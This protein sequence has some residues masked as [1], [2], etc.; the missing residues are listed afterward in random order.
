MTRDISHRGSPVWAARTGMGM[1]VVIANDVGMGRHAAGDLIAI[2]SDAGEIVVA[3]LIGPI[4]ADLPSQERWKVAGGWII[5][6]SSPTMAEI[7]PSTVIAT[8]QSGR[9]EWGALGLPDGLETSVHPADE[10][11]GVAE[12]TL[13]HASSGHRILEGNA[14]LTLAPGDRVAVAGRLGTVVFIDRR[15]RTAEIDHDGDVT[16]HDFDDIETQEST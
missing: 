2:R 9:H 16:V 15:K 10:A 7:A 14:L 4:A 12:A 13:A 3:R 11:A 1:V 8:G 5:G 6:G